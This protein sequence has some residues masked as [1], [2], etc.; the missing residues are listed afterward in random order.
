MSK[1]GKKKQNDSGSSS[2]SSEEGSSS[3]DNMSVEEKTPPA[4]KKA[5]SNKFVT[6]K[7]KSSSDP[8]DSADLELDL[9]TFSLQNE[10]GKPLD[11]SRY[12][13]WSF[14]L[15]ASLPLTA[16]EGCE[17]SIPSSATAN[18]T[19]GALSS[20]DDDNSPATFEGDKGDSY[21]FRWG[22]KVENDSFRLLIPQNQGAGSDSDDDSYD[23]TRNNGENKKLLAP[24]EMPFQRHINVVSQME[25]LV[26]TK[27]A[28][29]ADRA[30]KA[31]AKSAVKASGPFTKLRK[32][33]QHRPQKQG[34]KRR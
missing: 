27:V 13:L 1:N 15:P 17:L 14:R 2:S 6:P 29:G 32:A 26:A 12:E 5:T 7:S 30:P 3:D 4:K 20:A 28:P 8:K 9:P 18:V 23:G 10:N 34:L 11:P 16:L 24:T 31:D 33:Y 19:G 21:C 25:E 22:N